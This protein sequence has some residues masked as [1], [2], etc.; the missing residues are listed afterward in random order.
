VA[1]TGIAVIDPEWA[2]RVEVVDALR[3]SGFGAFG[4]S[5]LR[6][7]EDEKREVALVLLRTE[8]AEDMRA[9]LEHIAQSAGL[10]SAPVI[11]VGG[12]DGGFEA[13][14]AL[15]LGADDYVSVDVD[16]QELCARIEA[17]LKGRQ[18]VAQLARQHREAAMVLELTQ[19]LSSAL[20]LREILGLVVRRVAEVIAVDRVSIVLRGS[21]GRG[22]VVVTSDDDELRDLPI[23]FEDYPEIER[24]LES[25]CPLEIEDASGHPL[26]A[27]PA[28]TGP[29][30]FRSLMLFPIAFQDRTMGVLFLRNQQPTVLTVDDGFLLRALANATGIALRNARLLQS[31]RDQSARVRDQ[32]ARDEQRIRLLERYL[33]LFNSSADGIVVATLAGDVLFCNP[34]A[35]RMTGRAEEELRGHRLEDMLFADGRKRL[36]ELQDGFAQSIFPSS[37][38]LPIR[39]NNDDRRVVNVSFNSMLEDH[40]AVI[41]NFRDV[42]DERALAREL[43]KTKEFLQRVIDSSVDA[44]VSANTRGEVL[45]FNP[46]AERTYGYSSDEVLGH[47][48]V[49]ELYPDGVAREHMRLM[50]SDEY[51]PVGILQG[52]ETELLGKGELRIPVMLSAALIS[53]RGRV[54]GSVGVFRD[55]RARRHIEERLAA[56]ERE[57]EQKQKQA[58][59]AELAGA[60][61]HE[62]NQPLTAVM[63]YA[64][65]LGRK[66]EESSPLAHASSA[67]LRET[68]RMAEIVRKIGK[69]TKY[70][71]KTYVGDTKIIDIDRSIDSEPPV[72]GR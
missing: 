24:V 22:Y 3:I 10:R 6:G 16:P 13:M 41:L 47:M 1:S 2:R 33:D 65:M 52:Y 59:I 63:G 40:Q 42:T 69:L 31:L 25:G 21:D 70:E 28:I 45:L 5:S 29:S 72:T 7:L 19:A 15:Q 26:F 9:G 60:T 68:E 38:D 49:A 39:T 48:N 43:T 66:L 20:D 17:R 67:I 11:V 37:V 35:C 56:T 55:L 51:G 23:R 54:T 36:R 18:R 64:E 58:L 14:H 4:V 62:L 46:A 50:R 34:A 8:D 71:T 61:A 30:H 27:V 53:H 57:L 12:S 32:R 44:I